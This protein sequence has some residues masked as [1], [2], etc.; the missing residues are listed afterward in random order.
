MH[1]R[2]IDI[3]N[4]EYHDSDEDGLPGVLT[5]QVDYFLK[6]KR[7][8]AKFKFNLRIEELQEYHSMREIMKDMSCLV[9]SYP[10]VIEDDGK[11]HKLTE[12]KQGNYIIKFTDLMGNEPD[13][14]DWWDVIKVEEFQKRADR[15]SDVIVDT[16]IGAYQ[17]QIFDEEHVVLDFEDNEKGKNIFDIYLKDIKNETQRNKTKKAMLK[18]INM[19]GT[20]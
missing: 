6:D 11:I 9:L 1:L 10:L 2:L 13:R 15:A 4:V 19:V 5:M 20:Q 12:K 14:D 18:A 7:W 3:S 16:H 8:R 17:K